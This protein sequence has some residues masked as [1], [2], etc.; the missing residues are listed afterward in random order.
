MYINEK[1]LNFLFSNKLRYEGQSETYF[2]SKE[3]LGDLLITQGRIV[4]ADPYAINNGIV[5]SENIP[6]G[7]FPVSI[8]SMHDS[9]YDEIKV[10][11]FLMQFKENEEPDEW[12]MC[13][14]SGINQNLI[15]S[16]GY[17]GL[18]TESG[19]LTI[20]TQQTVGWLLSH[21]KESADVLEDIEQQINATYFENG[22]VANTI[23]PGLEVNLIT[24]V[25][26]EAKGYP[27][28]W[29]Y[30]NGNVVCMSVD[31]LVVD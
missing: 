31:F 9:V 13:L 19:N 21:I 26:N 18:E 1:F 10:A 3:P 20:C 2:I 27:A 15:Q 5:V 25:G 24:M 29:G 11:A 14:P 12:R 6:N 7:K 8:F 30:K 17:Y 4:M 22:G 23:L 16:D 28:Y